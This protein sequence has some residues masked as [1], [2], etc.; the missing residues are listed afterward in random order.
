MQTSD[1]LLAIFIILGFL[2]IFPLFWCGVVYLI[3]F[4]GWQQLAASF[5]THQ[6]MPSDLQTGSGMINL[7]RYNYTLRFKA[8]DRG[9]WLRT[10]RLFSPGHKPLFIPWSAVEHDE[11]GEAFWG[12]QT[13][14]KVKGVTIRLNHNIKPH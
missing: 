7:S 12:Y 5:A 13:K 14:L 11:G 9:L 2:I 3:S 4:F 10:M 6:P 1:T 8:D